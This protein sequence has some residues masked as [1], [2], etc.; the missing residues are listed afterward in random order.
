LGGGVWRCG[1]EVAD[2]CFEVLNFVECDKRT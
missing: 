2:N 1:E